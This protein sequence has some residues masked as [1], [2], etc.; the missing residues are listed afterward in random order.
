MHVQCPRQFRGLVG[1]VAALTPMPVDLLQAH[2]IG[3][4]VTDLGRDASEIQ[5]TIDA[6][7]VMDVEGHHPDRPIGA[8]WLDPGGRGRGR[9]DTDGHGWAPRGRAEVHEGLP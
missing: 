8:G 9:R 2:D 7:A 5:A 4:G 3:A 1:E 6:P